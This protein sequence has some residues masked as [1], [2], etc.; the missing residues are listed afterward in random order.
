MPNRF[1]LVPSLCKWPTARDYEMKI[2]TLLETQ[3]DLLLTLCQQNDTGKVND[4]R[5]CNG[6]VGGGGGGKGGRSGSVA[7]GGGQVWWSQPQFY[8]VCFV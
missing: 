4:I 1:K 2:T 3:T 8:S 6:G 5:E 7:G